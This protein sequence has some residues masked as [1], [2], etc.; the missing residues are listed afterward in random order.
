MPEIEET[1]SSIL[2]W[3][4][5]RPLWQQDAL[6]RLVVQG[7]L[8]DADKAELIGMVRQWVGLPVSGV[9]AAARRLETTDFPSTGTGE[10]VLG[11][12]SLK[13]LAG[14]NA[15]AEGQI[16]SFGPTGLTVVYGENGAGKSGYFR[17]LKHA[18]QARVVEPIL[19]DV[20]QPASPRLRATF[21]VVGTADGDSP[22]PISWNGATAPPDLKQFS[23]FDTSCGRQIVGTASDPVFLPAGLEAFSPFAAFLDE[24]RG[25]L[26][27]E[28]QKLRDDRHL[29]ACLSE[30]RGDH[31]I[32]RLLTSFPNQV[33][34]EAI[35]TAAAFSDADAE[36][37]RA[38][39][40]RLKEL[41]AANPAT[42]I[43]NL[44]SLQKRVSQ[45]RLR[46]TAFRDRIGD[47][48]QRS[49]R[50]RWESRRVAQEAREHARGLRSKDDPL[51]GVGSDS[52]RVLFNAAREYSIQDAYRD[53]VFP[54]TGAGSKCVLCMQPLDEEAAD[55]LRRFEA[56]IQDAS[57]QLAA[58]KD[59]EW[60][61]VFARLAGT[62]LDPPNPVFLEE[63]NRES[64]SI[65][66][67]LLADCEELKRCHTQ[68]VESYQAGIQPGD[69]QVRIG[70][71]EALTNMEAS[72]GERVG[73]LQ[74]GNPLAE[75]APLR[76]HR[77]A[78]LARQNLGRHKS[79]LVDFL[80]QKSVADKIA[81]LLPSLATRG[82]TERQKALATSA[83]AGRYGDALNREITALGVDRFLLRYKS[84]A[85]KGQVLQQLEIPDARISVKPEMVLSEGEHR[86]AALA[87]F[88]AEVSLRASSSGIILDDPVSSL[89]HRW[90]ERIA[91]RLV[92][93]AKHRQVIVFTHHLHFLYTLRR[94]AELPDLK[95]P[96]MTQT[97]RWRG[98]K[99]GGVF[100]GLPWKARDLGERVNGLDR[101]LAEARRH[102]ADD[103]E[104]EAY[105]AI[106]S[107]FVGFLRATWE[108]LI[109]E[110]LFNGVVTRFQSGVSTLKLLDVVVE[111]QDYEA[112][113]R[114]MTWTSGRIDAHDHSIHV[115]ESDQSPTDLEQ[116]LTHLKAYRDQLTGRQKATRAGRKLPAF[117]TQTPGR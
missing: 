116:A 11:L 26:E 100:E 87:A 96:F 102:H 1:I 43:A 27:A 14:V 8:S 114:G 55:R 106:R 78:L 56:F 95:I 99:P 15:L 17:V 89:D 65:H 24:V 74:A 70:I 59:A 88:L 37:L 3:S 103:P 68:L 48:A 40:A 109:E 64:P 92:E 16:L 94:L 31:E 93:E 73:S 49:L 45:E 113:T 71:L 81:T 82:V 69:V 19:G 80:R 38:V 91:S 57:E 63:I 42:M 39:E 90:T 117:Q 2:S 18:C 50:E 86:V 35:E 62:R 25:F 104:G 23:L 85:A 98:T 36:A 13:D 22:R 7:E 72:L 4:A 33:T 6:R 75:A 115:A 5:E 29:G 60:S 101:M 41:E 9:V 110:G 105:G 21:E 66:S 30:L 47:E 97:V 84:S 53:Q 107:S 61:E 54:V 111:D 32:G 10:A 51:P 44:D 76:S 67:Q 46:L 28:T 79:S 108:R 112:I 83:I 52:W 77:A 34:A 20:R 58:Q 12:V